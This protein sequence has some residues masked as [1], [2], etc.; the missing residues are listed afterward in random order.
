MINMTA[1][2]SRHF[3]VTQTANPHMESETRD[4]HTW[5]RADPNIRLFY[6]A[7]ILITTNMHLFEPDKESYSV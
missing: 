5:F 1:S 2:I 7:R 3:F 4:E 6:D